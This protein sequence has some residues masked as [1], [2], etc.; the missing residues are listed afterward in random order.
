MD[1]TFWKNVEHR[2]YH[3]LFDIEDKCVP[4]Y[5]S[6]MKLIK[7]FFVHSNILIP[8]NKYLCIAQKFCGFKL[9]KSYQM[10][11]GSTQ[12]Y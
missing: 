1:T 10:Y 2:R 5:F 7:M 8:D 3:Q 12:F 4:F 11:P 6:I 9:I